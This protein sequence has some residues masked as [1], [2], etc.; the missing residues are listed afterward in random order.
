MW[1]FRF[2]MR[3]RRGLPNMVL[4]LLSQSPKNGVELMQGVE[5]I[6]R[7]WWRPTAGSIYPLLKEMTEKG[8]IRKI[9]GGNDDGRYVLTDEG[10]THAE[11]FS[12]HRRHRPRTTDEMLTQTH[13]FVSYMEDVKGTGRDDVKPHIENIRGLAKRLAALAGDKEEAKESTP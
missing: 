7:G 3:K 6:T 11:P 13:S 10:R 12:A 8:L 9:E 5:E 1:P 4:F 2:P